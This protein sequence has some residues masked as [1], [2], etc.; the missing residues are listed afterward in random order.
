M[1]FPDGPI[2][3]VQSG[4][5]E[6]F[7]DSENGRTWDD[8]PDFDLRD[9]FSA[10][11]S[12]GVEIRVF[13]LVMRHDILDVHELDRHLSRSVQHRHR[14]FRFRCNPV[15]VKPEISTARAYRLVEGGDDG[16]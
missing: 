7:L 13:D 16:D 8:G 15:K 11:A 2:E 3:V 14:G 1:H 5:E 6:G 10:L 9:G 4:F 12:N